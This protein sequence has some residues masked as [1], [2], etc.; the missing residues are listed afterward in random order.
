M[1]EEAAS[2]CFCLQPWLQEQ[3]WQQGLDHD[4]LKEALIQRLLQ[5]QGS[6]Q[7]IAAA[8]AARAEAQGELAPAAAPA[9]VAAPRGAAGGGAGAT[10]LGATRAAKGYPKPEAAAD[11]GAAEMKSVAN[12]EVVSAS[13]Q[14]GHTA[15][16]SSSSSSSRGKCQSTATVAVAALRRSKSVDLEPH[17]QQQLEG[18]VAEAVV[19]PHTLGSAD[20]Q[21]SVFH[22]PPS[23]VADATA[24]T[25]RSNR[26]YSLEELL[27]QLQ[28]TPKSST[29]VAAARNS[30]ERA[31]CDP[32]ADVDQLAA[33]VAKN[34]SPASLVAVARACY[35]REE[36]E[37]RLAVALSDA[38]A[39]LASGMGPRELHTVL[40][41]MAA[42]P[43]QHTGRG[44]RV[45]AEALVKQGSAL[46]PMQL[47]EV[48]QLLQAMGFDDA[49]GLYLITKEAARRLGEFSPRDLQGLVVAVAEMSV[50]DVAL[51]EEVAHVV[52]EKKGEYSEQQLQEIGKALQ[53]MGWEVPEGWRVEQP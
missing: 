3:C 28:E 53:L 18:V 13:P 36:V 17:Q 43:Q 40:R 8:E 38:V 25:S 9:A 39:S 4:G 45:L 23:S 10:A 47:S 32:A 27:Q 51:A 41:L 11:V 2:C 22:K 12:G 24:R 16:S 31:A 52:E 26:S 48:V 30:L 6:P 15:S 1:F 20:F 37:E 7:G 34:S 49:W 14:A 29:A 5:W 19:S 50:G 35:G 42:H 46:S 21:S 44:L 33:A